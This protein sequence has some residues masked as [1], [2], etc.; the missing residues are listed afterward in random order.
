MREL[1]AAAATSRHSTFLSTD[2]AWLNALLA[3]NALTP[4]VIGS[5]SA[6]AAK[7]G[8]RW[9]RA[10]SGALVLHLAVAGLT[11]WHRDGLAA[12]SPGTGS[13][14]IDVIMLPAWPQPGNHPSQLGSVAASRLLPTPNPPA[15]PS[16]PPAALQPTGIA[17]ALPDTDHSVSAPIVDAASPWPMPTASA[18]LRPDVPPS[19]PSAEETIWEGRVLARLAS[20][21]RYPVLAQRAGLQDSVMVR[22]IM[23]RTGRV[24]SAEIDKSRGFPLLDS[25]ATALIRRA[26][27]LPAPPASMIGDEIQLV[28]PI[29]F[30]LRRSL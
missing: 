23:D 24:L 9:G 20:F 15:G 22:F 26:S 25:E 14:A 27:P 2:D 16:T 4:P 17:A 10:V 18:T 1:R 28:A 6:N 21:K 19:T 5:A 11:L 7:P 29:R 8:R 12:P 3:A 13:S 30:F